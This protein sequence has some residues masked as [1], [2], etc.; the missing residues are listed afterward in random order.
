MSFDYIGLIFPLIPFSFAMYS[1][2]KGNMKHVAINLAAAIFVTMQ[3]MFVLEIG[4]S[5][6]LYRIDSNLFRI[7]SEIIKI[8]GKIK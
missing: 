1:L 2:S 6:N 7:E 4:M 5:N 3:Q 8:G